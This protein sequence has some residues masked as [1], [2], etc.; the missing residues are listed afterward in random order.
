MIPVCFMR[1]SSWWPYK[2]FETCVPYDCSDDL[3][4]LI[5][6]A[7]GNAEAA[8]AWLMHKLSRPIC[9]AIISMPLPPASLQVPGREGSS[10]RAHNEDLR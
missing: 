4:I 8:V 7:A 3:Q 1:Q 5:G 2:L 6:Q 9:R 10:S